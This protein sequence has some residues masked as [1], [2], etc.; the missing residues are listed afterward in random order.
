MWDNVA[1]NYIPF[2][3]LERYHENNVYKV[4]LKSIEELEIDSEE[5]A[6]YKKE[7]DKLCDELNEDLK[8]SLALLH[9]ESEYDWI[10]WLDRH[11]YEHLGSDYWEYT[12]IGKVVDL[13]CKLHLY[14]IK[15]ISDM[16]QEKNNE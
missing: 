11:G 2:S 1:D 15:L 6:S 10:N 7:F 14:G 12:D 16:L 4:R 13:R 8:E 5:Y 3:Y 9:V